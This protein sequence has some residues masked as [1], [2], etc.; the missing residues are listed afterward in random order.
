V[1]GVE[2]LRDRVASMNA[3][4]VR[5]FIPKGIGEINIDIRQTEIDVTDY[6]SPA[7]QAVESQPPR[8]QAW[9]PRL[10]AWEATEF[11][12]CPLYFDDVPLERYGQMRHPLIQPVLSGAHFFGN[13]PLLPYK[14]GIDRPCDKIATLGYYRVGSCAPP[15]GRWL[16]LEVDAAA[17]EAVTW[18][19][20]IAILP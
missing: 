7:F 14:M 1:P 2:R 20:L 13:V 11:W 8:D 15:V 3:G 6:A 4:G 19:A 16:P 10:F 17:F 12:H 5:M 18:I 9:T